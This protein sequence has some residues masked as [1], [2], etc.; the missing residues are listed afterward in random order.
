[1]RKEKV[2]IVYAM[3]KKSGKE[4]EGRIALVLPDRVLYRFGK[5]S[6]TKEELLLYSLV[7]ILA[8]LQGYEK[9]RY[10]GLEVDSS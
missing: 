9:G 5:Q 1:M 4:D 2:V 6:V 3:I 7:D 8:K 10:V